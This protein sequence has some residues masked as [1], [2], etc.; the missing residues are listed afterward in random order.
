L[1]AC[2]TQ[3]ALRALYL[4]SGMA[5]SL[6]VLVPGLLFTTNPSLSASATRTPRFPA[7]GTYDFYSFQKNDKNHRVNH[8]LGLPV[9][10][11]GARPGRPTTGGDLDS[12]E[13]TRG[14][15]ETGYDAFTSSDDP[16]SSSLLSFMAGE[17]GSINLEAMVVDALKACEVGQGWPEVV[18]GGGQPRPRPPLRDC[19][20]RLAHGVEWEHVATWLEYKFKQYA[21]PVARNWR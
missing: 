17:A 9:Q 6:I 11:L 14:D 3:V 19:I 13:V 21:P 16:L 10:D 7:P 20:A 4:A 15:P 5:L 12:I 18:P 1:F 8:F 2:R